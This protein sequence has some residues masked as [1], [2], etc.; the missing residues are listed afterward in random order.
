MEHRSFSAIRSE[1]RKVRWIWLVYLVLYEVAIPWYW[2]DKYVGPIVLGFPLWVA[3][4]L[5]AIFVL[6]V[7]TAFVIHRF[8]RVDDEEGL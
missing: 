1:P 8:W 2:P 3:T 7:W 6:A 5:S 4:T